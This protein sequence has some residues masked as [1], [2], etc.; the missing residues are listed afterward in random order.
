MVKHYGGGWLG[1][2]DNDRRCIELEIEPTADIKLAQWGV[3]HG[4]RARSKAEVHQP[5]GVDRVYKSCHEDAPIAILQRE[6]MRRCRLRVT[7]HFYRL[8]NFELDGMRPATL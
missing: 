4:Q 3:N 7:S 6:T 1:E 2:V 8:V 5:I